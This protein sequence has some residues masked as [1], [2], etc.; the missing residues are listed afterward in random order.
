MTKGK[1]VIVQDGN[2]EKAI[3]KFKKMVSEDGILQEVLSKQHYVKPTTKRKLAK[4]QAVKRW[5]KKL[6][7]EILPKKLF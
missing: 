5:R 1:R 4:S 7:E 3:R 2:F 6:Q